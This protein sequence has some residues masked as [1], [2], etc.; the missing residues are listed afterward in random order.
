MPAFVGYAA[1]FFL[2]LASGLG[3]VFAVAYVRVGGDRG[4]LQAA[5]S[6]FAI[7]A[8]GLMSGALANAI[9]LSG[10]AFGAARLE[11]S[12]AAARL[13]L[14]PSRATRLGVGA[15]VGGLIGLSF[16][17][18][19][20]SD[21]LGVRG[22][23]VMDTLADALRAPSASRF[24]LA[25]ATIALAPGF[26]EEVFF[27]GF[28]ETRLRAS[29]GPRAAIVVTAAAFGLI[30]LDPVQGVLAFVAG[31]FLGW[32]VERLGGIRPAVAA[33]ATNN[34]IFVAL[35]ALPSNETS[36]GAAMV[37]LIA[38]SALAAVSIKL[39]QSPR[40]RRDEPLR[41]STRAS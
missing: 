14:G 28:M 35:A 9:A 20:A 10:V 16:A 25:I 4:K 12:P 41:A 32:S 2:V 40:A 6:A 37:A 38:G 22:G 36:R 24:A 39:L 29:W 13:R 8:P 34:S 15:V 30:H 3:I 17:T 5:A 26:A 31:L 19:A 27:R 7:S 18:G 23:G 21:L 33:H 1:A 11:R